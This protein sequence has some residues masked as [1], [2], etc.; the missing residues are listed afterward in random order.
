M[1]PGSCILMDTCSTSS[2]CNNEEMILNICDCPSDEFLTV[3][4]NGGSKTFTQMENFK[5]LPMEVYFNP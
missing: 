5:F 1:I 2:V 3:Y 4:N